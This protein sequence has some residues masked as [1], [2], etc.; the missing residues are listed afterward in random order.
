MVEWLASIALRSCLCRPRLCR[1]GL[2]GSSRISSAPCGRKKATRK[3]HAGECRGIPSRCRVP[4]SGRADQ[5]IGGSSAKRSAPSGRAD[6]NTPRSALPPLREASALECGQGGGR[7]GDL[8]INSTN[9]PSRT[10]R[11]N[12]NFNMNTIE[13]KTISCKIQRDST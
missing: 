6:R 13:K 7:E 9:S 8:G 3:V 11:T 10:C 1:P 12:L 2:V 5:L 4:R